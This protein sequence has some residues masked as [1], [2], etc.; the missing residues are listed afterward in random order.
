MFKLFGPHLYSE[1]S[2]DAKFCYQ[3]PILTFPTDAY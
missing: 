2:S 1:S 3:G